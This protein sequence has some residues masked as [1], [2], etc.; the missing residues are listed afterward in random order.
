MQQ[1]FSVFENFFLSGGEAA[2]RTQ[3][4]LLQDR[5]IS[6]ALA[7]QLAYFSIKL[8]AESVRPDRTWAFTP[9]R[10]PTVCI[11]QFCQLSNQSEEDLNLWGL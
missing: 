5:S 1:K 7:Y 8:L 4:P 11:C 3:K 9:S 6:S 10:L 2:T